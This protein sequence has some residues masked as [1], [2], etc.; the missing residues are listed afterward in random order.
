MRPV[1]PYPGA[2]CFTCTHVGYLEQLEYIVHVVKGAVSQKPGG[3][4]VL[5]CGGRDRLWSGG[6]GGG[7]WC[8]EH[9]NL[10]EAHGGMPTSHCFVAR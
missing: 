1:I 5:G 8:Q 2:K 10:F 7:P 4:S 6:G 9:E 3:E